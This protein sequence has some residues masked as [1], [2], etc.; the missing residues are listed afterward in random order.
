LIEA[1]GD[2]SEC[3]VLH[4]EVAAILFACQKYKNLK[5][6][7]LTLYSTGEP[8]AMCAAAACWANVG[9]IVYGTDISYMKQLWGEGIEGS[10]RCRDVIK[11]FPKCPQLLE[12]ICKEECDQMF[13]SY[14]AAFYEFWNTKRWEIQESI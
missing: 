9:T 13:L 12:S 5:W 1:I 10:L 4:A 7:E 6:S 3:P 11:T 14:K 2:C 8:C